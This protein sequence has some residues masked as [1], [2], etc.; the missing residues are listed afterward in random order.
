MLNPIPE[1]LTYSFFAP[2]LLRVVV[3]GI[4]AYELY[5]QFQNRE[6]ISQLRYPL[7]RGPAVFWTAAAL[8]VVIIIAL[9]LGYFTQYAAIAAAVLSFRGIVQLKRDRGLFCLSRTTY[10][11]LLAICISLLATGAGAL[12]LDLPL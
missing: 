2:T 7:L 3:A 1:L 10:V 5:S 4:L 8:G 6:E 11:L 9:L 12:A